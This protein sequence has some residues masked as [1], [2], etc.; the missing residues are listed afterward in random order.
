MIFLPGVQLES[1]EKQR[2]R[3]IDAKDLF[4]Y[5]LDF[6]F[7]NT[8][9]RLDSLQLSSDKSGKSQCAIM[10]RR[11]MN[12]SKD[13][14]AEGRVR[15]SI[16][17]YGERL[18]KDLLKAFDRAYRRGN[19]RDMRVR[20]FLCTLEYLQFPKEYAEVLYDFNGGTSVVQVFVNQH[21]FFIV[22][23]KLE[24]RKATLWSNET[25]TQTRVL[26]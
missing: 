21:D 24:T 14:D 5:Y 23:E 2:R 17:K 1:I 26:F 16:E 19:F 12:L 8:S 7:E 3:A 22:R 20:S 4:T 13:L 10:T 6:A 15:E 18:E 11:L 25:S 9:D